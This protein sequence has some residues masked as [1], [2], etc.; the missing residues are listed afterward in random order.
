M[1]RQDARVEMRQMRLLRDHPEM[2]DALAARDIS[3][4]WALAIGEWTRKLPAELRTET[5]KILVQAA[6]AGASLD[7]LRTI[8]GIAL[9]KWRASRPD[10]DEDGFDD[11]YVQVGTTFQG[12]GVI[13]GNLTPECAAAVQA[14]LE[15]LGKKAGPEDPRTE[16]QRFHDAL[17][18]GCELLIRA[19]MVPDRAGADTHVAVH[20]PFPE[21]RQRPGAPEAEEVWLRG[22][23]GEPGYL[24]GKDA[25]AAAC[26]AVAEPVV[27]GHADMRVVDKIIALTLAAA[28][29]TLDG[30]DAGQRGGGHDD[31]AGPDDSH[32]LWGIAGGGPRAASRARGRARERFTPDAAQALRYAIARLAIDFVSGPSGIAGWLRT[33]LLAPPHN[34]PSLPLDIGYSDSIPAS[35]RRAV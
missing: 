14:V 10:A 31:D 9:E 34:T 7:D 11:R 20:I 15:A 13:R 35:I 16:G 3:R 29:I 12:A 21:L 2:A 32:R 22:K 26:D 6:A 25:E 4:S 19:K 8:A 28:G 33:T 17:Q 27:T 1:T 30:A 5:I 18:Q 24:T 23:A